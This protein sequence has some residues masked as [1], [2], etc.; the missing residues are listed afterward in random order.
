M[1][2]VRLCPDNYKLQ[3]TNYGISKPSTPYFTCYIYISVQFFNS[4]IPQLTP[5]NIFL[6]FIYIN[7]SPNAKPKSDTLSIHV[8]IHPLFGQ[9]SWLSQP[10]LR[11]DFPF[12][13]KRP[14]CDLVILFRY[15][16]LHYLHTTHIS[17]HC[18]LLYTTGTFNSAAL[19]VIP[20]ERG[21]VI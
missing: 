4:S 13:A 21:K 8:T 7:P 18:P 3:T 20:K 11:L 6:Y 15:R 14:G 12:R 1:A 10:P 19:A 5:L 16:Q 2:V 17:L 9:I